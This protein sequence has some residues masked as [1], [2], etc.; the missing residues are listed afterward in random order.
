MA[1]LPP[2]LA[3]RIA[4]A[5]HV[6]GLTQR[7]L[8][9]KVG[10]DIRTVQGWE[11]GKRVPRDIGQ[12]ERVLGV[13]LRTPRGSVA[14]RLDE[15]SDAQITAELA[16]RLADRDRLVRDLRRQLDHHERESAA[17]SAVVSGPGH[18]WA[19]REDRDPPSTRP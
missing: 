18:R 8:A 4:D 3:Q 15:A 10:T 19:A 16:G 7:E 2:D 1:Q 12:A 14:P 6:A 9:A 11:S 17:D 13:D 5:R